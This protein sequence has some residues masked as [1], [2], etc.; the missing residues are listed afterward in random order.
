MIELNIDS[1]VSGLYKL[2]V[3]KKDGSIS[4]TGWFKNLITDGGMDRRATN[5]D[6]I[7]YCQ[8]G[9]G[10]ATP[11]YSDTQLSGR[12][13]GSDTYYSFSEGVASTSPYYAYVIKTYSFAA[14]VATGNISEVGVGWATTGSLFSRALVVDGSGNPTSITVLSD[15]E[16]RVAY[17]FRVYV[18]LN[19]VSGSVVLGGTTYNYTARASMA[20]TSSTSTASWLSV[21]ATETVSRPTTQYVAVYN[22]SIGAITSVPSG[23]SVGGATSQIA[24]AYTKGSFSVAQTATWGSTLGNVSGG[25]SA[26]KIQ[27]GCGCYQFGFSPAIPK[28]NTKVLSLK[29][30]H[31]WGRS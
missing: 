26:M 8:V 20:T 9:S 1:Q 24:D 10:S 13:A 5:A 16:L 22:G 11:S 15:E 19:D 31:S 17:Q 4:S 2:E 28:D 21:Q 3:V 29:I 14:G 6:Y 7:N 23:T 30:T 25:I 27:L 18:P 12:I